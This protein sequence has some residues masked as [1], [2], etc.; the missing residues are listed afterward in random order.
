MSCDDNKEKGSSSDTYILWMNFDIVAALH[1]RVLKT[2]VLR[3]KGV[4]HTAVK[5]LL[6][7][8]QYGIKF[9]SAVQL[10]GSVH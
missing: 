1:S 6:Y 8:H 2:V 9:Y 3:W 10:R 7:F 4:R 5:G